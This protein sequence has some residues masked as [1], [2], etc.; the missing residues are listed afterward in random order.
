M[1][2]YKSLFSIFLPLDWLAQFFANLGGN[3]AAYLEGT[4]GIDDDEGR[5][6]GRQDNGEKILNRL[7][8]GA[9]WQNT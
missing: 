9:L 5:E 3:D 2:L 1:K 4:Q 8:G 6:T 7:Q